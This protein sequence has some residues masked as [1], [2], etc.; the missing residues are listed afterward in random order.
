M[1]KIKHIIISILV[2]ASVWFLFHLLFRYD[3]QAQQVVRILESD[4]NDYGLS[5]MTSNRSMGFKKPSSC[6][7]SVN[8]ID[9]DLRFSPR[10]NCPSF[11][12]GWEVILYRSQNFFTGNDRLWIDCKP[13]ITLNKPKHYKLTELNQLF[14]ETL[15]KRH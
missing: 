4:C 14:G 2:L 15:N 8:A 3:L 1:V 10:S 9:S 6:V 11:T 7:A 12:K 5:S 13:Y